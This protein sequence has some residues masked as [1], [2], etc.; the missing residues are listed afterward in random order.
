MQGDKGT[1]PARLLIADDHDLVR[2]GL[3]RMLSREPGLEV[4]G[5]ASDGRM[6]VE[7]C[8][9]LKPD[10]ILMDVRMPE[11]DGLEATRTIKQA[12]PEVSILIVTT[13]VSPDY[14]FE[15]LKAGAA[16]YVL[17][18]AP[19]A[20]L[21]NSVRRV[22]EGESPLN[23]ELATTLIQRLAREVHRRKQPPARTGGPSTA[24]QS[25]ED[26]TPR[27]LEVIGLLAQGQTN[28]EIAR[29]LVISRGTAKVHVEHI[30][31]KLG[32]SD[33]TQAVVHAIELGLIRPTIEG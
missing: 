28:P 18:D 10:L 3:Q 25:V 1:R 4:V 19:K 8:R 21:I 7:L 2:D 32:V 24:S 6:A 14:L 30:I 9:R 5:E 15:A 12:Q 29:T 16:G 26:L 33:R 27:E 13:Y 22:I 23:Q 17:K 20:Q 11:M 31:R